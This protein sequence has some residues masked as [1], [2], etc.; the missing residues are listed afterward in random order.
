MQL[1][2][3]GSRLYEQGLLVRQ[4]QRVPPIEEYRHVERTTQLETL[5]EPEVER[6]VPRR[7]VAV[8]RA[9][10]NS[11]E[12]G[13]RRRADLAVTEVDEL[14]ERQPASQRQDSEEADILKDG[15]HR[16]PVL[17]IDREHQSRGPADVVLPA[18]VEQQQR[19]WRCRRNAREGR[20]V[21]R[22]PEDQARVRVRIRSGASRVDEAV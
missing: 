9:L 11:L 12:S 3:R 7:R 5:G 15:S 4:V 16:R 13:K 22:G 8:D 19:L 21:R 6:P 2:E 10:R 14:G 17:P 18:L 20:E 1:V